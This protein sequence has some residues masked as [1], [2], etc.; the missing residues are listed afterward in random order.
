MPVHKS[1]GFTIGKAAHDAGHVLTVAAGVALI[2]LAG[3]LPLA[4]VLALAWWI[5]AALRRRSRLQALDQV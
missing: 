3:L 5:Y 4:L 2:G 1:S